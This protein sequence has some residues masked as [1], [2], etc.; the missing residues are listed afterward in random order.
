MQNP[1]LFSVKNEPSLVNFKNY[2]HRVDN[3]YQPSMSN[4]KVLHHCL[5]ISNLHSTYIA[6]LRFELYIFLF[7]FYPQEGT[8]M[9]YVL[10]YFIFKVSTS[11][12]VKT[13]AVSDVPASMFYLNVNFHMICCVN[14]LALMTIA[15]YIQS[16]Y[17]LY[18]Y[19][20]TSHNYFTAI[21]SCY[22]M[23]ALNNRYTRCIQ[24]LNY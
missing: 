4:L 2:H 14:Y 22:L 13:M 17:W 7:N 21:S 1:A 20:M 6:S 23:T 15:E 5:I 12:N 19:M 9:W 18:M 11:T 10:N 3:S 8:T 16:Q 24:S